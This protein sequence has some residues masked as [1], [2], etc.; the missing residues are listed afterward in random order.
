MAMV[1]AYTLDISALPAGLNPISDEGKNLFNEFVAA[2]KIIGFDSVWDELANE[3]VDE[4]LYADQAAMDEHMAA[5]KAIADFVPEGVTL[6]TSSSREA[7]AED[8]ARL[9]F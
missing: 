1:Y 5:T 7:T 9:T 4:V 3:K 6:K 2:G 8:I